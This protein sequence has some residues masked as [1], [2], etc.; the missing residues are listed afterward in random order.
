MPL[1]KEKKKNL[2][3]EFRINPKDTGSAPVQISILTERMAVLSEHFK[4]APKDHA[5]K[6]GLLGIISLR[7][8][9]LDYLKRT[10][11]DRYQKLIQRLEIRK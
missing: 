3:E 6:Q 8:Q 4:K 10:D 2:I 1:L 7:R 11:L 5:S 9:L